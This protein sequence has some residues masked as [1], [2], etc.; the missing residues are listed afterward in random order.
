MLRRRAAVVAAATVAGLV[1]CGGALSTGAVIAESK[2]SQRGSSSDSRNASSSKSWKSSW[3][4]TRA[5]ATATPTPTPTPVPTATAAAPTAAPTV[6]QTPHLEPG[7]GV[8]K[9]EVQADSTMPVGDLI[10]WSQVWAQDFTTAAPL[11]QFGSVY[12]EAL[13]GYD[14]FSDTFGNGIYSPEKVLSVSGG[15]LDYYI[16][17]A[18]GAPRVAA[19]VANDYE[20]QTYGRYSIRFRSDVMPGYK[21]AFLLWPSSDDW[22]EGEIDFPEGNLG[23]KLYGASAKAGSYTNG[24]MTFDP[25]VHSFTPTDSTDWHTA[26]TEWTP[27]SVKWYWDGV[28]VGET[29]DP[30]AVPTTDMRWTL[31]AETTSDGVPDPS[32]SGHIQIDWMVQYEYEG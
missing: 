12:G 25:P 4:P 16:H 8:T 7:D 23:E 31:Q 22:N 32:V 3:Q 1:L 13:K 9:V 29:T 2:G 6:P 18:D 5:T 19:P 21:M 11:G 15:L 30:A 20:G 28:L 10:G 14:G 24:R 26:T 17:T 27:G